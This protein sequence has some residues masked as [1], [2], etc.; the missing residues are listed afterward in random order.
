MITLR[1]SNPQA[2]PPPTANSNEARPIGLRLGNIFERKLGYCEFHH[3]TDSHPTE[4]QARPPPTGA[5]ERL[6]IPTAGL[7]KS[8]P[9]DFLIQPMAT[10]RATTDTRRGRAPHP[11]AAQPA[12]AL[13]DP[14]E[15]TAISHRRYQR[16]T[17]LCRRSWPTYDAPRRTAS[18]VGGPGA[19]VA[20]CQREGWA[21]VRP[22]SNVCIFLRSVVSV[23]IAAKVA[24]FH[25]PGIFNQCYWCCS[26][27]I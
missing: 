4:R 22:R 19:C 6:R 13:P 18:H 21:A 12:D 2:T 3:S 15:G 9:D 24:L 17:A 25:E 7:L 8:E 1:S 14:L 26:C 5:A 11:R 27:S 23:V 20:A 16:R 10:T